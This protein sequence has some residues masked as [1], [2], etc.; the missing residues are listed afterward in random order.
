MGFLTDDE[1]AESPVHSY[2]SLFF[3]MPHYWLAQI[4]T[5]RLVIG[6]NCRAVQ[7]SVSQSSRGASHKQH[8]NT[9]NRPNEHQRPAQYK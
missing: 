2:Q 6:A 8:A 7:L 9:K 3:E 5:V 1:L 4:A